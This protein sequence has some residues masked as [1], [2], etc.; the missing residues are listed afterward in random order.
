MDVDGSISDEID[1]II[2]D[3]HFSP[4]LFHHAQTCYVPAESVYGVFEVKP[5]LNLENVR[6]AG[7]KAAS[8]RAHRRTSTEIP[9][10][11]GRFEPREVPSILAGLLTSASTWTDPRPKLH[12]VLSALQPPSRIQLGCSAR[13]L[14]FHATYGDSMTVHVSRPDKALVF[15]VLHLLRELQAVG[16]V[17]AIDY[18]AYLRVLD[19]DC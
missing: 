16:S 10:A 9:H 8:V 6:Y 17:P 18:T 11:G 3:R 7:Q 19:R 1:I 15:F 5:E 4:L 2:H 13:N 14:A 12:E